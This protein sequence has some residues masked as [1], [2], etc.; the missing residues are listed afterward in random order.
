[1]AD[2][3]MNQFTT[4]KDGAYIYAEAADGIQVKISKADLI[5]LIK[6][7]MLG[8]YGNI[9]D[10]NDVTGYNKCGIYTVFK[11]AQNIPSITSNSAILLMTSCTGYFVQELIE[12][13]TTNRW[14][15]SYSTSWTP[16]EKIN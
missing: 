2:K 16:W 12:P 5:A 15:R 6:P 3:Q 10:A 14:A 13:F 8:V 9:A 4:A 7:E 1:M 11:T